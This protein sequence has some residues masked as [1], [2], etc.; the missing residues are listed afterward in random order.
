[1]ILVNIVYTVIDSFTDPTNEV[2]TRV[3]EVQRD[4]Q[5]GYSASMAWS[6]FGI[7]LIALGI[8]FAIMNKLVWYDD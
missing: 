2:M 8:I 1:M 6:Y 5:Y 4:W 3:L 7:I